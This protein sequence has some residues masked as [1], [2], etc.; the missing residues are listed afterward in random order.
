MSRKKKGAPLVDLSYAQAVPVLPFQ[1]TRIRLSLV[2]LGGTGSF[3]A[4]H[5]ACLVALLLSAGKEAHLTFIDP[6]R[7]E[8]GNIPRQHFCAAEIGQYKAQTLARRYA[9]GLGIEIG[10]IPTEFDPALIRIAWDELTVL[11]GCVDRASGR[12]AMES[13]LKENRMHVERKAAPRVWY[14]D[15]GNT[16]DSG[17][18]CLGST[19]RVEDL[20]HAFSLSKLACVSLLPSPLMQQPKLREPRPE[21]LTNHALSCAEL[22][23]ANAQALT[24]NPAMAVEGADYLYR[25]LITGDLKK[26]ATFIDLPS[27]SMRSRYTTRETLADTLGR[28]TAFFKRPVS[29]PPGQA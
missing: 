2:G 23:A 22:L 28:P 18:I 3:L 12:V 4:R 29:S 21:E 15:L 13:V 11:V 14:L 25:L 9:E 1:A 20:E 8:A 6:D 27:G 5:V 10:F 16:L 7:V 26:F 19:E 17:Q 24:V